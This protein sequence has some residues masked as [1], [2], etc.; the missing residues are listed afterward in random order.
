MLTVI[1]A[2]TGGIVGTGRRG[3]ARICTTMLILTIGAA[4]GCHSRPQTD[5]PAPG[6]PPP[7]TPE[8]ERVVAHVPGQTFVTFA[9]DRA[10]HAEAQVP[11]AR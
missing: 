8:I 2:A 4:I 7:A 6:A 5:E 9:L 3:P 11:L 10:A 1:R